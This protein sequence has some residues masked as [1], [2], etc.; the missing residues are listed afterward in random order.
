LQR[1]PQKVDETI[2]V[3]EAKLVHALEINAGLQK[4]FKRCTRENRGSIQALLLEM[5]PFKRP[6]ELKESAEKLPIV[7][8]LGPVNPRTL[9]NL[10]EMYSP[11]VVEKHLRYSFSKD[12]Y[13]KAISE[14]RIERLPIL[15][16]EIFSMEEAAT[17]VLTHANMV[18][19]LEKLTTALTV[20]G[21]LPT[22]KEIEKARADTQANAI[23]AIRKSEE[24]KRA[25][26]QASEKAIAAAENDIY[27]KRKKQEA[28]RI[29][30]EDNV[31][32]EEQALQAK[33]N[34]MQND[35][36]VMISKFKGYKS[37][38]VA[39]NQHL[40]FYLK[41]YLAGIAS[42]AAA[43]I[44]K[45][46]NAVLDAIIV[47]SAR[48]RSA[49][50]PQE[51]NQESIKIWAKSVC[52]IV[53][54]E[55]SKGEKDQRQW[56]AWVEN[57]K[58]IERS[59][60]DVASFFSQPVTPA[61]RA[62]LI[63]LKPSF[64]LDK[65]KAPASLYL[66]HTPAQVTEWLGKGE[67]VK[68]SEHPFF[69]ME[70]ILPTIDLFLFPSADPVN[71]G[72]SAQ[73]NRVM[74]IITPA[75]KQWLAT[76]K[77]L[78]DGNEWQWLLS[79]KHIKGDGTNDEYDGSVTR[80]FTG[81]EPKWRSGLP[82]LGTTEVSQWWEDVFTR[83]DTMSF[84]FDPRQMTI[85][86]EKKS[87][88]VERAIK[89]YQQPLNEGLGTVLTTLGKIAVSVIRGIS[90]LAIMASA[91]VLV[92]GFFNWLADRA[93]AA[94]PKFIIGR[95]GKPIMRD[96][97]PAKGFGEHLSMVVVYGLAKTG[98]WFAPEKFA[99]W[100]LD[101]ILDRISAG[102]I[103]AYVL[104]RAGSSAVY[105]DFDATNSGT[106]AAKTVTVGVEEYSCELAGKA[107]T[108]AVLDARSK[109]VTQVGVIPVGTKLEILSLNK[110]GDYWWLRR[111]E[112]I[113]AP[114][115]KKL[116]A[117]KYI[118]YKINAIAFLQLI[119]ASEVSVESAIKQNYPALFQTASSLEE[120][121]AVFHSAGY[122]EMANF[123]T[124][125][126]DVSMGEVAAKLDPQAVQAVINAA[127]QEPEAEEEEEEEEE[128]EPTAEE[129]KDMEQEVADAEAS[130]TGED[131]EILAKIESVKKADAAKR[132]ALAGELLIILR[133]KREQGKL[134][135][136]ELNFLRLMGE[137]ISRNR[138]KILT[139][140]E[141]TGKP[142]EYLPPTNQKEMQEQ[143][144]IG[145]LQTPDGTVISKDQA[146]Q[147]LSK[148]L[149]NMADQVGHGGGSDVKPP[150]STK[151]ASEEVPEV[152]TAPEEPPAPP[153]EPPAPEEEK[154]VEEP[155][156]EEEKTAPEE[157]EEE[158]PEEETGEEEEAEEEEKKK[159]LKK[160]ESMAREINFRRLLGLKKALSSGEFSL[161]ASTITEGDLVQLRRVGR[162]E[163]PARQMM[164]LRQAKV[165]RLVS[166]LAESD[167]IVQLLAS[168]LK[169]SALQ[170]AMR[171]PAAKNYAAAEVGFAMGQLNALS[172]SG[173]MLLEADEMSGITAMSELPPALPAEDI[174]PTP[175][176]IEA[177]EVMQG[178]EM[179]L[180][181]DK[182]ASAGVEMADSSCGCVDSVKMALLQ[183]EIGASYLETGNIEG[184]LSRAHELVPSASEE[185]IVAA[186]SD[187]SNT[188]P[189]EELPT[190]MDAPAPESGMEY[191]GELAPEIVSPVS[192]PVVVEP[193]T[194][195]APALDVNYEASAESELPAHEGLL[196]KRRGTICEVGVGKKVMQL[197]NSRLRLLPAGSDLNSCLHEMVRGVPVEKITRRRLYSRVFA[198]PIGKIPQ[199]RIPESASYLLAYFKESAGKEALVGQYGGYLLEGVA[200]F[201]LANLSKT[202][203]ASLLSSLDKE[204]HY[205]VCTRTSV[206][207]NPIFPICE[208]LEVP[209]GA[210]G[211]EAAKSF[212]D[213]M[214]IL[215]TANKAIVDFEGL[216]GKIRS[217]VSINPGGK[218]TSNALEKLFD[219]TKEVLKEMK[220][221]MEKFSQVH[222]T[223]TS[224][225]PDT[226]E[227]PK[228]EAPAV[229][230]PAPEPPV[231]ATEPTPVEE[232][233]A[234]TPAKEEVPPDAVKKAQEAAE[235]IISKHRLTETAKYEHRAKLG[236]LVLH[237][238]PNANSQEV[239]RIVSALLERLE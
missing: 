190:D 40:I 48:G 77:F 199:A 36:A 208:Q 227:A 144:K 76:S 206:R 111:A 75:L 209:E 149:H 161:K 194:Q 44:K 171:L 191:P 146:K 232:P 8:N 134:T 141:T 152:K 140:E 196:L 136:A 50:G 132:V 96:V 82:D 65:W 18:S 72:A 26:L 217:L 133:Q 71:V 162:Y 33:L 4:A 34:G 21:T 53:G 1:A 180:N 74:H 214:A 100:Y 225:F 192:E 215:S 24:Q 106:T 224:E 120:L 7:A 90:S 27:I 64:P 25:A 167:Q 139:E 127:L 187:L 166:A 135:P 236:R 186:V 97:P 14:G 69:K 147:M 79:L 12:G 165:H 173:D 160:T 13:T 185:D 109:L 112:V 158:V 47:D 156:A 211:Q 115:V 198:V 123:I 20:T 35:L 223:F 107:P 114:T 239:D 124:D 11:D 229:E 30:Y 154:E 108:G 202:K 104:A 210:E 98:R 221:V 155:P 5:Y 95:N 116:E 3:D 230:E 42:F 201:P 235:R 184:A 85:T 137:S 216:V 203:R 188:T 143:P 86:L 164:E 15:E 46:M 181:Q 57:K 101:L 22:E 119:G 205:L 138:K 37:P 41:E 89:V 176:E 81:I 28:E 105:D 17:P 129:L 110:T 83:D 118:Y 195:F 56:Q 2:I 220:D 29:S 23:V 174:P 62:E 99:P 102:A 32:K 169:A 228:A 234:E 207:C 92:K 157:A 182:M 54:N 213:A 80:S 178:T 67:F 16:N 19:E 113:P 168:G 159:K 204:K 193:Q 172:S 31:A 226:G 55:P 10:C 70:F 233:P 38:Q 6:K 63:K 51:R 73:V 189:N 66:Q 59:V 94:G 179:T 163:T 177:G 43:I 197:P 142:T 153:E 126:S 103:S 151:P 219:E 145:D 91:V 93:R 238:E 84:N 122:S 121:V 130:E 68:L 200:V 218:K 60:E 9:A 49:W 117:I 222:D 39:R 212:Q 148:M 52:P 128:R 88:T 58:R 131:P 45:E 231:E 150:E 175:L 87:L 183:D 61:M 78:G 170:C 125:K 237:E